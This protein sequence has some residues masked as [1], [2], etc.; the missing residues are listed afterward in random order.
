MRER[1]R[2]RRNSRIGSM[3]RLVPRT[4]T[5]LGTTRT[6]GTGMDCM[7]YIQTLATATAVL[8]YERC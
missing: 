2:E 7:D 4:W 6:S 1:M 3:V 5:A 8:V